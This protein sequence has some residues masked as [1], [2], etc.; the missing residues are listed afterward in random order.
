MAGSRRDDAWLDTIGGSI[1]AVCNHFATPHAQSDGTTIDEHSAILI[2]TL[3]DCCA[4]CNEAVKPY[5]GAL[6]LLILLA[7]VGR[8]HATPPA[9]GALLGEGGITHLTIMAADMSTE[10][11]MLTSLDYF[12]DSISIG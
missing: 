2:K 3:A 7:C 9:G 11:Q 4:A 10:E 5:S 1:L 12:S 6:I 8:A